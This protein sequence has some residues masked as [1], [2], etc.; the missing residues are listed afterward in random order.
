MTEGELSELRARLVESTALFQYML[1]IDVAD[2]LVVGKGEKKSE[3][4]DS[5]NANL[6][7]ALLGAIYLDAGL[8]KARD[9]LFYHLEAEFLKIIQS[10]NRNWKAELQDYSQRHFQVKPTYLVTKEEGPDHDKHFQISVQINDEVLGTGTGSS[11]KEAERNAAK[12]AIQTQETQ[13]PD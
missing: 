11:K 4:R 3:R 6:V 13:T 9:F 5:H 10:P 7:E 12:A 8:Q 2:F 1:K